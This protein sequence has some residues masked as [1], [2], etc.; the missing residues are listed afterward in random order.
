MR[1]N[2][3]DV[4]T[5]LAKDFTG[6]GNFII[7]VGIIILLAAIGRVLKIPLSMK[8]LIS[9]IIVVYLVKQDGIFTKFEQ[10]LSA[11]A[12]PAPTSRAAVGS[13]AS[14][15]APNVKPGATPQ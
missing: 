3:D 5:Q 11:G 6:S 14:I 13:S 7:W 12:S 1:G 9:L 8:L 15:P 4:A 10:G 2:Q